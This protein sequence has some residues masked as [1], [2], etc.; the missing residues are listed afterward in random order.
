MIL[1]HLIGLYKYQKDSNIEYRQQDENSQW[2]NYHAD[3]LTA[4]SLFEAYLYLFETVST[5]HFQVNMLY[6]M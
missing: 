2:K 3:T 6:A 5:S 1:E 4:S